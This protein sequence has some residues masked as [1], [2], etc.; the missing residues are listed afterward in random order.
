MRVDLDAKKTVLLIGVVYTL[1]TVTSAAVGLAIGQTMDTHVHILLRFVVTS[2][3][4]GS[5]HLFNWFPRWPLPGAFAFH[6]GVTMGAIWLLVWISGS[7]LTLHPDAYRDIFLNYSVI[8]LLVA[9]GFIG[10][11]KC[12]RRDF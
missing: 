2:F 7:F 5:I 1:L 4:V 10:V 11:K 6:Y 8:Y 3:G 9:A 12:R